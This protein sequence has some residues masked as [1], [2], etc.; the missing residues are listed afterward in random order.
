MGCQDVKQR[1]SNIK[2]I[3]EFLGGSTALRLVPNT[4]H[5][6]GCIQVDDGTAFFVWR[7]VGTE[8]DT[9]RKSTS[10]VRLFKIHRNMDAI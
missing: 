4:K 9:E 3:P 5:G 8:R 1:R 7:R 10:T 6:E 2:N